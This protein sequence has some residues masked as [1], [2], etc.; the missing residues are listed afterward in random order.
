MPNPYQAIDSTLTPMN[1][2]RSERRFVIAAM[3]SFVLG[4]VVAIPGLVML[5][6]E[7]QLIST[8]SGIYDIQFEGRV[9]SN[10]TVIW[11]T[12]IAGCTL[13]LIG[14][15]P[16]AKAIRNRKHNRRLQTT[17]PLQDAGKPL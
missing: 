8:S 6:Q 7:L 11:T 5:N 16:T 9:Y 3:L 13:L 1:R 4:T 12:L 15:I 2:R 17:N 14:L 10:A